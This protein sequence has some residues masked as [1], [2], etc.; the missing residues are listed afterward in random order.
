[1]EQMTLALKSTAQKLHPYFLAHRV[2]VLTNQPLRSTLYKLDLSG[3]MLKWAIELSVYRIK[4]QSRTSRASKSGVEYEVVL[5]GLDLAITLAVTRLEIR[6]DSQLITGQIQ[7]EYEA[8]DEH[9]ACYLT[10]MHDIVKYLKTGELPEDEKQMHK[11]RIQTTRFTLISDHLYRRSFGGPYLRCL[12]NPKAK[13]VL[14]ELYEGV[15]GNHPNKQ[16]LAHCAH[17]QGYY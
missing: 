4:Y 12:S 13:Y 7:K 9:M 5:T 1:M 10:M 17:T 6:S 2:I 8:K 16:T 11:L 15:C 14:A 3:R